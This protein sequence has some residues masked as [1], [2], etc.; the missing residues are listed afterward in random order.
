[1]ELIIILLVVLLGSVLSFFSGF[2]LG[3]ILLPTFSLFFSI[4]LAIFA[5]AIVHFFNSFFKFTFI[6]RSINFRLLLK[7]GGTAIPFALLGAWILKKADKSIL[8]IQYDL[9]FY[10]QDVSLIQFSIGLVMISFA[11]VELFLKK[12]QFNTS[13]IGLYFGGALSGFFGGFS[14]H[15]GALRAM[16]LSKTNVTKEEFVATSSTIGL[17]IDLTRIGVYTSYIPILA[18]SSIH[19][20]LVAAIVVAF[21]GSYLGSKILQKTTMKVVQFLVSIL[22]MSVGFLLILGLL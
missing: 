22:L 7:F 19:F 20:T 12:K 5:T 21:C 6:F 8:L 9:P 18:S 16:F 14:G 15:Q 13:D 2:G 11:F 3:T 4:E 17:L 1:L 10:Q